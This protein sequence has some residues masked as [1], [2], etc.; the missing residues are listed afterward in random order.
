M[1]QLKD[2]SQGYLLYRDID[3][4]SPPL[5][6]YSMLPFYDLG[7]TKVSMIPI[8]LADAFT[9]PV[10]YLIVRKFSTEKIATVAGFAYAF[11]PVAL[12]NEGYLW[13]NSQPMT[14]FLLVSVLLLRKGRPVLAS[15]SL[16]IAVLFNQGAAFVVPVFLIFMLKSRA[17][18]LKSGGV[19]ALTVLGVMS[20]FLIEAPNA[21]VSRLAFFNI[22]PLEP[23]RLPISTPSKLVSIGQSCAYTLVPHVYTGTVCGD[24][25][26]FQ[27]YVWFLEVS[28]IDAMATFIA[29]LLF[30]LFSAGFIAVRRSPN[31]LELA[32]GYAMIGGLFVFS[33]VVHTSFAYYFVPVYALVW[34]SVTSSRSLI[35][36]AAAT[37]LGYLSGEGP[38]QLIIPITCIFAFTLIQ[39]ASL[40]ASTASPGS[41]VVP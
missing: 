8:V 31:I 4:N 18:L 3:Y 32:C 22:G 5:F 30:V 1:A 36:A 16:A 41:P 15:G 17:P 24:V 27:A 38:F 23:G 14:L 40:R 2:L 29:P 25:A 35:V 9:A 10:V 33:A 21:V 19:F 13:L 11:S 12:V 7:G 20:P 26:N 6:L 39:D 34:A 37:I 28:K